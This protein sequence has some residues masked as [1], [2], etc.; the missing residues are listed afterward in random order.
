VPLL[1]EDIFEAEDSQHLKNILKN[2]L[3]PEDTPG[4]LSCFGL[5]EDEGPHELSPDPLVS[6]LL[7]T[8]DPKHVEANTAF[9]SSHQ[10]SHRHV[11]LMEQE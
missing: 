5:T 3:S 2:I 10:T 9:Y 11:P 8:A 7:V 1:Q 6:A 4:D